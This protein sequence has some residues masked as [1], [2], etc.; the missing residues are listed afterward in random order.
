MKKLP[1]K[2]KSLEASITPISVYIK[3]VSYTYTSDEG[4]NDRSLFIPN[5]PTRNAIATKLI[6]ESGEF[7]YGFKVVQTT[8]EGFA[9]IRESDGELLPFRFDIAGDFNE[10]RLAMVGKNG[11]VSWINTD[12]NFINSKGQFVPLQTSFQNDKFLNPTHFGTS[13][14][15][16]KAI[17]TFDH[18][19]EEKPAAF[20]SKDREGDCVSYINPNGELVK[21][22]RYDGKT[23]MDYICKIPLKDFKKYRQAE[24]DMSVLS[25]DS[26]GHLIL[27][28]KVLF[29][30]GFYIRLADLVEIGKTKG[31][32]SQIEEDGKRLFNSPIEDNK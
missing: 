24:T 15:A 12:F 21:F 8:S 13:D 26:N 2:F 11:E 30:N 25:F 7:S 32:L 23:I 3:K 14:S 31:W 29:S 17:Y 5:I 4:R 27:D 18:D 19:G 20:V 10:H 9:Y 6:D 28:D 1:T 16:W 22:Y